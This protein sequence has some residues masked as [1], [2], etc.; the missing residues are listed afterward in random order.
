MPFLDPDPC[1]RKFAADDKIVILT[2]GLLS[3]GKGIE[4]MIDAL[5]EIVASHPEILY[6]VVG[7][8]PSALQSRKW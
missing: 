4:F 8:H 2:F 1:K 7:S 5:P 6:F 3:A